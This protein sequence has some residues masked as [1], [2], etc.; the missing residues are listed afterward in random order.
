MFLNGVGHL[1]GSIY[2]DR[3]L[4]GATSAPLLLIASVMLGQRAKGKGQRA[5]VRSKDQV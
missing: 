1:A 4:P 5:K 2:F 3:W